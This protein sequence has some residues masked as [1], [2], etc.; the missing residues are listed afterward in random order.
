MHSLN[1]RVQQQKLGKL[2]LTKQTEAQAAN[3]EPRMAEKQG[4]NREYIYQAMRG[5][6]KQVGRT[7][8]Q[9]YTLTS[10]RK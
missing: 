10:E 6:C 8:G 9:N 5:E 7:D 4:E 2:T 3:M 1:E